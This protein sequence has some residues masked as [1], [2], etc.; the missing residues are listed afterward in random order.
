MLH[1][2]T[3]MF[4]TGLTIALLSAG[5]ADAQRPL[6][7]LEPRTP[8]YSAEF[9]KVV[10]ISGDNVFVM[11]KQAREAQPRLAVIRV[12]ERNGLDW[13]RTQTLTIPD[14]AHDFGFNTFYVSGDMLAAS[15]WI[16]DGKIRSSSNVFIYRR[17]QGNWTM[18][19]TLLHSRVGETVTLNYLDERFMAVSR[20]PEG[21]TYPRTIIV[22]AR[23]EDDSLQELGEL[24][25]YHYRMCMAGDDAVLQVYTD[26][27]IRDPQTGVL[28]IKRAEALR[29]FRLVGGEW[30]AVDTIVPRGLEIDA[31]DCEGDRVVVT[32]SVDA[33]LVEPGEQE[34]VIVTI[35]RRDAT[36]AWAVEQ[37]IDMT[38]NGIGVMSLKMHENHLF[39]SREYRS[40]DRSKSLG[41]IVL[42]EIRMFQYRNGSWEFLRTIE[43]PRPIR[44]SSHDNDGCI[45]YDMEVEG[46]FVVVSA[47]VR[48]R[49]QGRRIHS[50]GE[51]F[52]YSL[53]ELIGQQVVADQ[54]LETPNLEWSD[55]YPSPGRGATTLEYS[56]DAGATVHA[57]VFDAMGRRVAVLDTGSRGAGGHE[58]VFDSRDW[59][60]GVY[61]LR[62]RAN[63]TTPVV[64]SF[65]VM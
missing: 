47:P 52:I 16:V 65:V 7:H 59:V 20:S 15:G 26:G 46:D 39:V 22:Y 36:G 29:F 3:V 51:V 50:V 31:L 14:F 54:K 13:T 1:K 64:R 10:G 58:L 27:L 43:H 41:H 35:V 37:E 33:S 60:P 48:S 42:S 28:K 21:E 11:T 4:T 32:H 49:I 56:L 61:F 2:V 63:Q 19:D 38:A 44:G 34:E 57:A 40:P 17:E 24:P 55:V 8:R 30:N 53:Q 6:A 12:F 18:S 9:G 5:N 25:E 23:N 62:L 45:G